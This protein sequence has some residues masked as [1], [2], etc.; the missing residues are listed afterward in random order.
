MT[1][2]AGEYT[3]RGT[4]LEWEGR[5]TLSPRAAGQANFYETND[6]TFATIRRNRWGLNVV[7]SDEL[8]FGIDEHF[9]LSEVGDTF[10]PIDFPT[11]IATNGNVALISDFIL[12][13]GTSDISAYIDF[14]RVRNLINLSSSDQ[15]GQFTSFD[16]TTVQ[17]LPTAAATTNDRF[18]LGTPIA[19]GLSMGVSNFTR[20]SG[21][22]DYDPIRFGQTAGVQNPGSGPFVPGED[23]FVRRR[24]FPIRRRFST[25][26]RP[27]D[28]I[29][30][31]PSATY[32][33][34]YYSFHN[35]APNLNRG[36]LLLQADLSTQL[37]RIYDT[38]DPDRP[39]QKHLIRPMLTYSNIPIIQEDRTH[40]FL[41]QIQYAQTNGTSG[42]NFDDHDIVPVDQ[43]PSLQDYFDP[44]GNSLAYG[45]DTQLI[46]RNGAVDNPSPGYTT[47]VELTGGETLNFKQFEYSA[48][49]RQPFS[50]LFSTSNM[51]F[52]HYSSGTTYYY[53]PYAAVA[54]GEWRNVI[55]TTQSWIFER[56]VHQHI[57]TYDRSISLNFSQNQVGCTT[58]GCGT[59]DLSGQLAF[60]LNDYFLPTAYADYSFV[61]HSLNT[62]GL[63]LAFQSPASCW[64]V[65]MNVD[66]T[67]QTHT[68]AWSPNFLLN[69]SGSGFGTMSDATHN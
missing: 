23:P 8:P 51:S 63:G 1:I 60:S 55:S 17:E 16:S 14:K 65:T 3:A 49:D 33:G 62:A 52:G 54:S 45:F 40:P 61:S 36:Y 13:Y 46:T 28:V 18:I 15:V 35:A 21:P 2:G 48:Q 27:F 29:D 38:P 12:N 9:K 30:F 22:F 44:L 64:K 39:K 5:Y 50:R 37:E 26:L 43:S 24:A 6:K 67:V 58:G 10:Y 59:L 47:N 69:L 11:D 20:G 31:I 66:Y 41:K 57:L 32:Y 68:T 7:Q 19:A 56:A 34:Y 42:Y 25:T 53:Y 4:R